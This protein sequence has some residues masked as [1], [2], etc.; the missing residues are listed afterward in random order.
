MHEHEEPILSIFF[1]LRLYHWL[2][3]SVAC[4]RHENMGT[5]LRAT[6][7]QDFRP[8]GHHWLQPESWEFQLLNAPSEQIKTVK[9]STIQ[10]MPG[11]GLHVSSGLC[12]LTASLQPT[13]HIVPVNCWRL[14]EKLNCWRLECWWFGCVSFSAGRPGRTASTDVERL[15][16]DTLSCGDQ[17]GLEYSI[18]LSLSEFRY[19]T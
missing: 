17:L 9:T 7:D 15:R 13:L 6:D 1:S 11:D 3:L 4:W 19:L 8:G 10:K 12:C 5:W 2:I 16:L 14:F 18:G